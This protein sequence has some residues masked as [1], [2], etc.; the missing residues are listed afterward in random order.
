MKVSLLH[1]KLVAR[2]FIAVALVN[3]VACEVDTRVSIVDDGNPPQFKLSGNGTLITLFVHGP[4]PSLSG[5][6]KTVDEIKPVWKVATSFPGVSIP[7]LPRIKYGQVPDGFSQVEPKEGPPP[8]IVEGQYYMLTPVS[9]NANWH[10]ICFSVKA[11]KA[12]EVDCG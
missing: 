5:F 10:S 2:L 3:V 9:G 8:P 1:T 6:K 7:D 12:Q 4:E 11:D